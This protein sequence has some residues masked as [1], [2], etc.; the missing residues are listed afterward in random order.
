M[1]LPRKDPLMMYR[2]TAPRIRMYDVLETVG[3]RRG[4]DVGDRLEHNL[5]LC[6]DYYK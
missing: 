4:F 1:A 6:Y 2:S 3:P 5:Y